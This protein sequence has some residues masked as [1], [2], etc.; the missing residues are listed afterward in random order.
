MTGLFQDLRYATR[1][2]Q[3]QRQPS[4]SLLLHLT[5]RQWMPQSLAVPPRGTA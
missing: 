1:R 2:R 3:S 5:A 4:P